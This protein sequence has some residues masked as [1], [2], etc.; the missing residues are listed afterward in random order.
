MLMKIKIWSTP[1]LESNSKNVTLEICSTP[2]ILFC[3]L[4]LKIWID[5]NLEPTIKTKK[6]NQ[7]SLTPDFSF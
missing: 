4:K 3:L 2:D 7:I 5:Q 1:D 6:K